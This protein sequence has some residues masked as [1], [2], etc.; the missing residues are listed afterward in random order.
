MNDLS[1]SVLRRMAGAG[2]TEAAIGPMTLA[3]AAGL[4]VSRAAQDVLRVPLALKEAEHTEIALDQIG[5]LVPEQA[6]LVLL[7]GPG[8]AR[9]VIALDASLLAAILQAQTTGRVTGSEVPPRNPT[10]T[11]AVLTR[12]F[13]SVFLDT[14]ALRLE[15]QRLANWARAYT[16]RDQ[17]RDPKRLPHVLDDGVF[18]ALRITVDIAQG[19]RLGQLVLFLPGRGAMGAA[20]ATA[21]QEGRA[22][23]EAMASRVLD[24]QAEIEAVLMRMKL[25]LSKVSRL[26][27]GDVLPFAPALLG[28]VRLESAGGQVIGA[29]KLGKSGGM[30]A[31]KVVA[32]GVTPPHAA[33]AAADKPAAPKST[34]LTVVGAQKPAE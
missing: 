13:V 6:L 14:L 33:G 22:W 29:A 26:A 15:G 3:R 2:R 19:V 9:G 10:Q 24:S 27:V 4:A 31:V 32:G 28:R 18:G 1:P 17:V 30:R 25:P 5:D 20:D 16:A 21:S 11:D 8:G 34:E 7:H 12:R 23:E